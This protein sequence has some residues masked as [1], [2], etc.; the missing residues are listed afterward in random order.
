M[1]ALSGGQTWR[2][3]AT[4]RA[5]GR[6]HR[7]KV[8]DRRGRPSRR[9]LE[10]RLRRFRDRDDGVLPADVAAERHHRGP[11]QGPRGLFQPQQPDV[12]RLVRH[13]RAVRRPYRV[14]RGRAGVRP[15][16]RADHRRQAPGRSS[17]PRTATTRSSPNCTAPEPAKASA[18]ARWPTTRKPM[19]DRRQAARP[20]GHAS[21]ARS[22]RRSDV[23]AA[24]PAGRAS[25]SP[26]AEI[27]AE[28]ARQEKAAFEQAA[29]QIKEAVR[30]DPALAEL[31]KQLAI[32][33]TP[34]GLRIQIIDE[35]KLPMFPTGSATPNE[36]ARLLMQKIVPVLMKLQSADLDRRAYRRRA[37][38]GPGPDQL[39]TVG[40]TGQRH[41]PAAGR[42]RVARS[43]DQVGH[44]QR[45]PRSAAA[46]RS[47]GRGQPP[48]RHP[49][50]ARRAS[51]AVQPSPPPRRARAH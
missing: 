17:G 21:G 44:R 23:R 18:R 51:R 4:R 6:R 15:R 27:A 7:Q 24:R 10:G 13:R 42:W 5:Q 12:A 32:D 22:R 19:T 25:R 48:H 38:P 45:R 30:A 41:P 11:A 3:R 28:K 36:R 2:A 35:V 50:A 26:P 29:E 46:G 34:D 8:R 14:R 1:L 31:A 49:G 20:E 16:Q 9:R 39:G 33:M 40:R 37:V 43:A 47:A